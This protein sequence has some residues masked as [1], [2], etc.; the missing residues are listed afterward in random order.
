MWIISLLSK[1]YWL[2]CDKYVIE[3]VQHNGME[4]S[5]KLCTRVKNASYVTSWKTVL[6]VKVTVAQLVSAPPLTDT[7]DPIPLLKNIPEPLYFFSVRLNSILQ[8]VCRSSKW[9]L[10]FTFSDQYL[11]CISPSFTVTT[12]LQ[13]AK[14]GKVF[15]RHDVYPALHCADGSDFLGVLPT[16]FLAC[17]SLINKTNNRHSFSK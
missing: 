3:L 14:V 13:M 2:W 4:C 16:L 7:K 17:I 8:L 12:G 6:V 10:P 1:I 15:K 11:L 9:Y 5:A